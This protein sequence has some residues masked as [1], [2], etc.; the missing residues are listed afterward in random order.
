MSPDKVISFYPLFLFVTLHVKPV[1][2]VI[3]LFIWESRTFIFQ[4]AKSRAQEGSPV[5]MLFMKEKMHTNSS[6]TESLTKFYFDA[7]M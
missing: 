3:L 6:L 2:I 7:F 4:F 1:Y 5:T